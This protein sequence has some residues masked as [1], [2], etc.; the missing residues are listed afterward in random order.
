MA[1]GKPIDREAS[2]SGSCH[3]SSGE[4]DIS[5]TGDLLLPSLTVQRW[6][7]QVPRVM[8]P[9][10]DKSNPSHRELRGDDDIDGGDHLSVPSSPFMVPLQPQQLATYVRC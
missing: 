2:R 4:V 6:T 3:L 8:S 1:E 10:S 7:I 9:N 5:S